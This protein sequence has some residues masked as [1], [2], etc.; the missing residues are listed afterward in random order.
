MFMRCQ[1]KSFGA[2][3]L[4]QLH[5]CN[6]FSTKSLPLVQVK[7]ARDPVILS[8]EDFISLDEATDMLCMLRGSDLIPTTNYQE[9][10]F[11]KSAYCQEDL[12]FISTVERVLDRIPEDYRDSP[13]QMFVYA[14]TNFQDELIEEDI[15]Q[16]AN[17]LL[18]RQALERWKSEEGQALLGLSQNGFENV[19]QRYQIPSTL[20]SRLQRLVPRVLKGDWT[21]K[22][23]T[24]VQYEEGEGQPPHIDPCDATLLICLQQ[25][26]EGGDTCFPM[27]DQ[28]IPNK[29][30][31]GLLFFS[32]NTIN[33]DSGR[34]TMSLHHG[35]QV[36]KG[37][38]IVVQLMLDWQGGDGG[39]DE[40]GSSWLDVLSCI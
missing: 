24:A 25:S 15:V 33:G 9:D 13:M 16:G 7:N 6:G 12:H 8:L 20:L 22:D 4:L 2:Y 38:K 26:D 37:S 32:S 39:G 27:L 23:A 36:D 1:W 29:T 35:G 19:G 34:D 11:S 5:F 10:V 3:L 17:A 18:R 40:Q 14:V 21:L 30:G 31:N 28:S